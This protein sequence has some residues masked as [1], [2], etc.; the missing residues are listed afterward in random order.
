MD[1]AARGAFRERRIDVGFGLSAAAEDFGPD[2]AAALLSAEPAR[3][4]VL[5]GTHPLAARASVSLRHDLRDVPFVFFERSLF[6]PLYDWV[7][8]A[9]RD[10]GYRSP[11]TLVALPSF[12]AAAQ[13]VASGG[14]WTYVV[15]SV[16]T[17]PPPGTVIRPISNV[18][19]DLGFFALSRRDHA[20]PL[21]PG[22]IECLR[23]STRD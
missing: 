19:R 11:R 1:H 4:A 7:M 5:P 9:L 14:G 18:M 12:A 2:L 3:S 8:V 13:L 21:V 17:F 6:P 22:F 15:D 23:Q 16:A 10:A 20:N